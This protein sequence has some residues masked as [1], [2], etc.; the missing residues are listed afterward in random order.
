MSDIWQKTYSRTIYNRGNR[1]DVIRRPEKSGSTRPPAP[2][3]VWGTWKDDSQKDTDNTLQQQ[4]I[5][6]IESAHSRVFLMS[7]LLADEKVIETLLAASNRGVRIYGMIASAQTLERNEESEF[8]KKVLSS[9]TVMLNKLAGKILLRDASH[10]HGKI[11]LVDDEDGEMHG[12]L[13][14]A[15]L[16]K[17]ALLRNEELLVRLED[18]QARSAFEFLRYAFFEKA[19][20]ELS[21][22][23]NKL[24]ATDSRSKKPG[25]DLPA[26]FG[27]FLHTDGEN[28]LRDA[29]LGIISSA[30]H[31]LEISTFGIEEDNEVY[32]ALLDAIDRNVR[33]SI[34]LRYRSKHLPIVRKLIEAGADVMLYEHLHAKVVLAD[35]EQDGEG[36][37]MSANIEQQ[38]F[39]QSL[40]SGILLTPEAAGECGKWLDYWKAYQLIGAYIGDLDLKEHDSGHNYVQWDMDTRAT[41]L[42]D[43]QIL[44]E[45]RIDSGNII[46]E[47]AH[48]LIKEPKGLEQEAGKI[49]AKSVT[50]TWTVVAPQPDSKKLNE[51]QENY[52]VEVQ[53][54]ESYTYKDEKGKKQK[55]TKMVT[56]T[57]Q[58]KRSYEPPRYKINDRQVCVCSTAAELE[59]ARKLVE[60]GEVAAVYRAASPKS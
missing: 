28:S 20:N 21:M 59:K 6:L 13:L 49:L 12:V 46:A 42:K 17:E 37:I 57:E 48:S 54:E 3:Q 14:T 53:K 55:G 22:D 43:Y 24:V 58:R 16:T 33:T 38:S 31:T 51:I 9:H 18:E 25:L 56:K 32:T 34:H 30:A 27:N 11:V 39:E 35:R 47:S 41:D 23:G 1:Q 4:V 2:R 45:K 52:S 60:S 10:Y 15:N 36:L 50:Y 19:E 8:D 44:E 29:V 5:T 40:E 26:A 7:F